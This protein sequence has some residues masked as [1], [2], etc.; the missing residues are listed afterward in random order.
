MSSVITADHVN[1]IFGPPKEISRALSMI[2]DGDS[3]N[4]IRER[5]GCLVAVRDVSIAINPGELF[6]LM[7][8]SGSGKSTFLRCLNA[9]IPATSG[10]ITIAGTP[11]NPNDQRALTRLRRQHMTMVF[12]HFGLLPHRTVRDNVG[13]GLE[14]Q[15][16][17]PDQ[18]QQAVLEALERVGLQEWANAK[19]SELSGGMQQRVGIARALAT[20]APIMLMDEPFSALDPLI[21]REMQDELLRLQRDLGQTIVF[22]THD[23]NEAMKLGDR[24]G[25]M[26]EGELVQVGTAEEILSCPADDYVAQFVEDIDRGRALTASAIMRKPDPLS[27]NMGPRSAVRQMRQAGLSSAFVVDRNNR[28][29]GIL[30]V[31]H[32]ARALDQGLDSIRTLTDSNVLTVAPE[33]P[34]VD[35]ARGVA[36]ERVPAAVVDSDR[37]LLGL[38]TWVD[39]VATVGGL[40]VQEAVGGEG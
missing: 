17:S 36:T 24:I 16:Q 28:L 1:K 19:P 18:R 33:D 3:R 15:G 40:P 34:V 37:K 11:L 7:G 2:R 14:I 5:T 20:G 22:V 12:Q 10:T 29:V 4:L 35:V 6:V 9:I 31:D 30:R 21:R 25:I 39:I 13:F 8:L 26:R 23:L 27:V 38:V 32:A